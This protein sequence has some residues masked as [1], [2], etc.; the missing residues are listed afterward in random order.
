MEFED[1]FSEIEQDQKEQETIFFMIDQFI[2]KVDKKF[3]DLL[4]NN[5]SKIEIL[6]VKQIL[7]AIFEIWKCIVPRLIKGKNKF[8]GIAIEAMWKFLILTIDNLVKKTIVRIPHFDKIKLNLKFQTEKG[9]LNMKIK[10]L[11]KRLG[12]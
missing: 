8:Y 5:E 12:F 7:K 3:F 11:Y 4:I 10:N 2:Q 6:K 1:P 9:K